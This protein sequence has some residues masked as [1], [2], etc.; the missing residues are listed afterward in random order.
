M[1][2]D[3]TIKIF[4][5]NN[6]FSNNHLE[7]KIISCS[8]YII[9]NTRYYFECNIIITITLI[10]SIRDIISLSRIRS[11]IFFFKD[12]IVNIIYVEKIL[13]LV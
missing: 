13:D 7:N 4:T 5:Y 10:Y 9:F 8:Q 11:L 2:T 1:I 6:I 12:I 3:N